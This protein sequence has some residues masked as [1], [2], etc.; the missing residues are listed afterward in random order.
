M[1]K[2]RARAMHLFLLYWTQT[3]QCP[4]PRVAACGFSDDKAAVHAETDFFC[5]LA[6]RVLYHL[7]RMACTACVSARI[8][9]QKRFAKDQT[10]HT[11]QRYRSACRP[12]R[13]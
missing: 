9:T 3:L 1:L 8:T 5:A 12:C 10:D 13:S 6:Y 2:N 7:H 11:C 4:T